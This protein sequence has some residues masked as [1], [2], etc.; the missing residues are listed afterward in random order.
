MAGDYPRRYL[1]AMA[2]T[3]WLV[4]IELFRF[5]P[6]DD[7]ADALASS[8]SAIEAGGWSLSP[9]TGPALQPYAGLRL[10]HFTAIL[11]P[12]A[13]FRR[14]AATTASGREGTVRTAQARLGLRVQGEIGPA[15][16]GVEGAG[17]GGRATLDG[18]ELATGTTTLELGP[19]VGF[20]APL[21]EHLL[22]GARAR[23]LVVGS[24]GALSQGLSGALSLEWRSRTP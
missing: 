4:G 12:A 16:F 6:A 21:G 14:E 20:L 18:E 8:L 13:A 15:I 7:P 24:E 2:L 10:G 19:T 5:A 11:A 17:S 1:G 22:V 23:W 9:Y 3:H